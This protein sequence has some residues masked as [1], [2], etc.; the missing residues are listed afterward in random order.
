MYPIAFE[1]ITEVY[2]MAYAILAL[3]M[4][5]GT[6]QCC[7]KTSINDHAPK[8]FTYAHMRE[9]YI[10]RDNSFITDNK[11]KVEDCFFFMN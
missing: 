5:R 11:F 8:I 10:S 2:K 9:F 4:N 3:R 6:H 1:N 7:E